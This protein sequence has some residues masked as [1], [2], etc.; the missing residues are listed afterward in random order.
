VEPSASWEKLLKVIE[1]SAV[2][3]DEG[4][5]LIHTI[6]MTLHFHFIGENLVSILSQRVS[7]ISIQTRFTFDEDA[8]PPNQPKDFTPLLLV[9]HQ[10][11]H[12]I[13]HSNALAKIQ[14]SGVDNLAFTDSVPKCHQQDYHESLKETLDASKMTKQL[15]D[16]LAPL[17]ES[18]DPQ[19]IL[20]EGL[21]G[22]GKT[23]LFHTNGVQRNYYNHLN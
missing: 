23:L 19:F 20:I 6:V 1:S 18:N 16:I 13:E 4:K 2:T 7:Q 10:G 21:P 9:H 12:T 14:A 8:W 11:R 5:S 22:I 15:A 17:E 3:S